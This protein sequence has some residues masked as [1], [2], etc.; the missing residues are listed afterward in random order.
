MEGLHGDFFRR[1]EDDRTIAKI[2]SKLY[3]P[4]KMAEPTL[5]AYLRG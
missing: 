5:L 4:E 2:V 3:V 1:S